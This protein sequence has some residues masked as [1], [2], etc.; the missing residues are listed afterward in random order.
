MLALVLLGLASASN[1]EYL[2]SGQHGRPPPPAYYPQQ[3]GDPYASD[4]YGDMGGG[5]QPPP[6]PPPSS[7]INMP[8]HQP[9]DQEE[10]V[11]ERQKGFRV[12][13]ASSVSSG[14][15][16][17]GASKAASGSARTSWAGAGAIASVVF[18]VCGGRVGIASDA[19]GVATLDALSRIRAI[20]REGRYPVFKQLKSAIGLSQRNRFPPNTLDPWRYKPPSPTAPNF[21]M[22]QCLVGSAF[23]GGLSISALPSVPLLPSSLCA[24]V[25]AGLAV[26]L[27]TLDDT[28]GDAARCLVARAIAIV[29]IILASS[30][31]ARLPSKTASALRLGGAHISKLDARFGISKASTRIA[32]SVAGLVASRMSLPGDSS[33]R[34][35]SAPRRR[36]MPPPYPPQEEDLYADY[37]G[38]SPPNNMPPPPRHNQQGGAGYQQPYSSERDWY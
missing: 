35:S 22:L 16:S 19:L 3:R 32:S 21:S 2:P 17:L 8:P 1:N 36:G 27:V 12:R 31:D 38:R 23:L 37:T 30:S 25:A 5:Q 4:P 6:P 24:V 18:G 11:P 13:A 28:R 10:D 34:D 26:F 7:G 33:R 20:D 14:L 29:R 15:L 9:A